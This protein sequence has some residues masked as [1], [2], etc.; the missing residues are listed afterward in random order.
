MWSWFVGLGTSS[1]KVVPLGV[2]KKEVNL[3]TQKRASP[4]ECS[5]KALQNAVEV[6]LLGGKTRNDILNDFE[7]DGVTNA[8]FKHALQTTRSN[9]VNEQSC[10]LLRT[11]GRNPKVTP[12]ASTILKSQNT[13]ELARTNSFSRSNFASRAHPQLPPNQARPRQSRRA[14]H[15]C[16]RV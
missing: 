8:L 14:T 11:L 10:S 7:K 9:T 12:A 6:Y 2:A 5:E 4:S 3:T 13:P 1:S 15:P 16:R